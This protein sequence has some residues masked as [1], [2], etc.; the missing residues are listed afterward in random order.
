MEWLLFNTGVRKISPCIYFGLFPS[1]W[2]EIEHR[3]PFKEPY[4]DDLE[5]TE[6]V[7]ITH[8]HFGL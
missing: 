7:I 4:K 5:R 1:R 8:T 2:Q 3:L 6:A